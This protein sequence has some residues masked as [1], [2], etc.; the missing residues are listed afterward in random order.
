MTSLR[1]ISFACVAGLGLAALSS[2]DLLDWSAVQSVREEVGVRIHS[3]EWYQAAA[4]QIPGL[5]PSGA[6]SMGAVFMYAGR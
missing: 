2:S 5:A 3:T 1:K 6:Q 4:S